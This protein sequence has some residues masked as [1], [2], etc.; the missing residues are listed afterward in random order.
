MMK[1]R[2]S[3]AVCI[4]FIATFLCTPSHANTITLS[5]D[6]ALDA[7]DISGGGTLYSKT[8]S[9]VIPTLAVGDIL[10]TTINFTGGDRLVYTENANASQ[11]VRLLYFQNEGVTSIVS[12]T[13]TI[14]FLGLA[15]EYINANPINSLTDC[16]ACVSAQLVADLTNSSF[17]FS[18]IRITTEIT[19]MPDPFGIYELRF[20]GLNA[21]I[22]IASVPVP[23][24]IWLFGS[25]I[26]GLVGASK[27]NKS[28]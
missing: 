1:S 9:Q 14:E 6:I 28:A 3:V 12:A 7:N 17:S 10:D 27:R 21:D 25:G 15:G 26:L 22:S 8:I 23:A 16:N 18:G 24:S 4:S 20:D 5:Y 11:R 2:L 13:S 19:S